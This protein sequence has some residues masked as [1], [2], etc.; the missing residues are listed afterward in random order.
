[1]SCPMK[2][3]PEAIKPGMTCPASKKSK[4]EGGGFKNSG[5]SSVGADG[6]EVVTGPQHSQPGKGKGLYYH[7]YLQLDKL[8]SSQAPES[9]KLG[10]EAHE[11]LL[12]ITI[13]QVYE[14][15]FKQILHE[16]N[17]VIELF[18][19]EFVPDANVHTAVQRLRRVKGA[20]LRALASNRGTG[21][22]CV[23]VCVAGGW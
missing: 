16:V 6:E 2:S 12:F 14:L 10:N 13:H 15:W 1:M 18:T 5:M 11:E 21:C 19:P 23:C 4:A 20:A 8:L 22:V 7:D 3:N 17:S 9:A